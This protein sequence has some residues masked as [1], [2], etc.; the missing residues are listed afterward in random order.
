MQII[1]VIDLKD[2]HV[3][4]A[5]GGNRSHYQPI[6]TTS[7]LCDC[8]QLASVVETFLQL[9]PF[10]TLYIADLNA[11]DGL[12]DHQHEIKQLI[13]CYPHLRLWIDNGFQLEPANPTQIRHYQTIIGTESQT[14]PFDLSNTDFILSLD[15][16]HQQAL[17]HPGWLSKPEYWPDT[18]IV[19]TL[20]QVG[21]HQGPD[22]DK[23]TPL[24]KQ[25]PDKHF[26]AAGG[27]RHGDDLIRLEEIGISAVLLASALHH[28]NISAEEIEKRQTKK[29]PGKPGYF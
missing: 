19:M 11:I 18:V 23:L 5:T 27:V 8:S 16:K 20:D 21:S 25:Y 14:S 10:E 24:C 29:Y 22:F 4:H 9:Y 12:G 15:F 17:G 7:Q 13:D 6:H 1:P 28:G 3:V 26:V 2:G